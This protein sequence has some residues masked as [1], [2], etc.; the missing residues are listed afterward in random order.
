MSYFFIT[1]HDSYFGNKKKRYAMLDTL[2]AV[3]ANENQI[4]DVGIREEVD[5]FMFEGYDTTSAGIMFT[6]FMLAHHKNEQDLVYN[7]VVGVLGIQICLFCD[8]NYLLQYMRIGDRTVGDLSVQDLNSMQYF[9]M[10]IK[11]TLRL[12]PPVPFMGRQ[13]MESLRIGMSL[14]VLNAA[15]RV[16][17]FFLGDVELPVGTQ[18]HIHTFDL[19]RDPEQFPDPEKFDTSRFHPDRRNE[20]HPFAYVA[21]SAGPRNCIGSYAQCV[22]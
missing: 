3:E 1:I 5:T 19:H 21:F 11:E 4:D 8:Q 9:D 13:L 6:L 14:Y 17:R 12:Y 15:S 7:E 22:Y 20:R 18:I 16:D 10:F 2:F